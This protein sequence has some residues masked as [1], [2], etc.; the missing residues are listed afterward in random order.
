MSIRGAIASRTQLTERN[1]PLRERLRSLL[2]LAAAV[3]LADAAE[4]VLAV[5][6]VPLQ[7]DPLLRS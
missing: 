7:R 3:P 4:P 2:E 1:E 5:E 6:V